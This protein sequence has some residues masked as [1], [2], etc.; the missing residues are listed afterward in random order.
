MRKKVGPRSYL[1]ILSARAVIILTQRRCWHCVKR[2]GERVSE[3]WPASLSPLLRGGRGGGGGGL[4]KKKRQKRKDGEDSTLGA[5]TRPVTVNHH[6]KGQPPRQS[7]PAVWTGS[8]V[9]DLSSA[10]NVITRSK[11]TGGPLRNTHHHLISREP[12]SVRDWEGRGWGG[13][14]GGAVGVGSGGCLL[15]CCSSVSS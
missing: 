11:A 4:I 2:R 13:G 1:F 14:G 3:R 9:R 6:S 10:F 8:A 5:K 12:P 7:G 15:P